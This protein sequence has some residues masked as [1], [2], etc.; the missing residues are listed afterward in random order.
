MIHHVTDKAFKD[1]ALTNMR[2]LERL[3]P[4]Q[5][6]IEDLIKRICTKKGTFDE[7]QYRK[8][9]QARQ[10]VIEKTTYGD[11]A[12]W[13]YWG[14]TYPDVEPPAEYVEACNRDRD[15]SDKQT[16]VELQYDLL[17]DRLN[18]DF[19]IVGVNWGGDE[20]KLYGGK[21]PTMFRNYHSKSVTPFYGRKDKERWT[22]LFER[23]PLEGSYMTDAFK[24]VAST[25][26]ANLPVGLTRT[27]IG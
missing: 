27:P 8:K 19:I 14:S 12:S 17:K 25:T 5:S 26:S 6:D 9:L 4:M 10:Q 18:A 23:T 1:L 11:M 13:A 16:L 22:R 20:Q 21:G 7:V 15:D 24:G 3:A 2:L